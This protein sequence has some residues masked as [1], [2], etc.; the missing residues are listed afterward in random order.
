MAKTLTSVLRAVYQTIFDDR[1]TY[2]IKEKVSQEQ[3]CK[4]QCVF[5]IILPILEPNTQPKLVCS[6]FLCL[7]EKN[8][9]SRNYDLEKKTIHKYDALDALSQYP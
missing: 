5:H 4:C 8:S 3:S 7:C 9:L 6:V 1:K 2:G